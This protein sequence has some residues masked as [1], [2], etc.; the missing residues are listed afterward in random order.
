M[1]F[2]VALTIQRRIGGAAQLAHAARVASTTAT[3]HQAQPFST[4]AAPH[5]SSNI[6]SHQHRSLH[7]STTV[8]NDHRAPAQVPFPVGSSTL[9]VSVPS[10]VMDPEAFDAAV[11]NG[12]YRIG[13]IVW[14]SSVAFAEFLGQPS[15]AVEAEV[16]DLNFEGQRVL[17]LGSG[18]GLAGLALRAAALPTSVTLTDRDPE[19]LEL[20]ALS[21]ELNGFGDSV[22]TQVV[23]WQS[24]E[25]WPDRSQYDMV[26]ATDILYHGTEHDHLIG[27]LVH[28]L[29]GDGSGARS[30]TIVEPIHNER[31]TATDGQEF[32]SSATDAGLDVVVS[33]LPGP[34]PMQLIQVTMGRGAGGG[35]GAEEGELI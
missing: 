16:A 7:T 23:D 13:D 14:P 1:F 17:E 30:A 9:T 15:F 31:V 12:E 8:A 3:S 18:L 33:I 26:V 25:Q 19:V 4:A 32:E 10:Y 28:L 22:L 21:A 20:A 35:A 6:I 2:R 11:V 24:P 5:Y 27:L 34:R 29:D